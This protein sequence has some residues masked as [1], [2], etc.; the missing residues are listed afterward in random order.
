M[1]EK[2][3]WRNTLIPIP[4]FENY[5]ISP[6]GIVT[7][8]KNGKALKNSLN[9]NG[10]LY[11]SL[12][13]NN[14][15]N[16]KTVHRLVAEAYIPNPEN[17]PFVNHIDANRANPS[18]DNLEWVTQSENIQHAYNIGNMSQKRN[19]TNEQLEIALNKF[20]CGESQTAIASFFGIG[21]PRLTI[22]LRNHAVRTGRID[23]FAKELKRQKTLRNT[24]AN[25]NKK[26]GVV[27]LTLEGK[28]VATYPSLTEATRCLGKS[29]S[30]PISNVIN[31]RQ[32]TAYGYLWKY[33]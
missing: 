13:K 11:V 20:L 6:E 22:N 16:P 23:L 25:V 27:A 32:K 3:L 4:E 10:Y 5:L 26:Q 28:E 18:V 30:G 24:A 1:E 14:R 29:T 12:W 8:S 33:T 21:L 31:G 7:N 17:K 9:E 15:G 19:L 2:S